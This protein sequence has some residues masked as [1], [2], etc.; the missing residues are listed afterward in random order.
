MIRFSSFSVALKPHFISKNYE[1]VLSPYEA[2]EILLWALRAQIKSA[3]EA[4]LNKTATT[5]N[6]Y[7]FNSLWL[8]FLQFKVS[9][10]QKLL[11]V[12]NLFLLQLDD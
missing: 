12:A 9:T 7:D 3:F 11:S 2:T 8:E 6:T 5:I 4:Y 1:L 10:I